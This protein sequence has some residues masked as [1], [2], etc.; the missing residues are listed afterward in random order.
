MP[1]KAL[2]IG[3]W[4]STLLFVV[5]LGWSAVQYLTEAPK[6]VST[7]A[8]LGYPLYFVK[9]LGVAKLLGI[10]ALLF[11]PSRLKEW[12]YAGF[13]FDLIG[14]SV[15]HFSSGD[16][17]AIAA[18]PLAFLVLLAVSYFTWRRMGAS[19]LPPASAR[20]PRGLRPLTQ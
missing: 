5:A 18:V 10:A 4:V 17:P 13:T 15:S 2:R 3:Y 11:G 6:M 12:A 16:G 8:H 20:V 1:S 19:V 14:A 7:M 9:A